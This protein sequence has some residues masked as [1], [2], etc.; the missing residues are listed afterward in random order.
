MV[1]GS[2]CLRLTEQPSIKSRDAMK[3][4]T[5]KKSISQRHLEP[6]RLSTLWNDENNIIGANNSAASRGGP[7]GKCGGNTLG[8]K[9]SRGISPPPPRKIVLEFFPLSVSRHHVRNTPI[10]SAAVALLLPLVC[11]AWQITQVA[12]CLHRLLSSWGRKELS[13]SEIPCACRQTRDVYGN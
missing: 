2:G 3:C 12:N 5:S 1:A 10:P 9:T 11:S 13:L 4:N 6:G 8:F 7:S